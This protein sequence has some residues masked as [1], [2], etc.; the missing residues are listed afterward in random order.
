[1][2][3]KEY[4]SFG[5]TRQN[6][7]RLYRLGEIYQ[8]L[9]IVLPMSFDSK[10]ILPGM[11]PPSV[12]WPYNCLGQPGINWSTRGE[13]QTT[14]WFVIYTIIC[15]KLNLVLYMFA[16]HRLVCIIYMITFHTQYSATYPSPMNNLL[17]Y[18]YSIHNLCKLSIQAT[19]NVFRTLARFG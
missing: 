4:C 14:L 10:F 11:D 15:H 19:T 17:V 13:C 18:T 1:M 2:R 8:H 12:K 7:S 16:C 9:N 5:V 3:N 6:V